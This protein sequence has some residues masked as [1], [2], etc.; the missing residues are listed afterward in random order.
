[1]HRWTSI[2][3]VLLLAAM[4]MVGCSS[5]P[6]SSNGSS[7]NYMSGE[8]AA[9]LSTAAP[10]RSAATSSSAAATSA[11]LHLWETYNN[12]QTINVFRVTSDW[13]EL[14]VTWGNFG[15]AYDP[16]V[17]G[18]FV[19]DGY[20]PHMVDVT[21]LVQG[22]TDGSVPNYGLMLDQEIYNTPRAGW[23]SREVL[24]REPYLVIT[25]D[26]GSADT[27]IASGDT[28]IREIA[29]DNNYGSSNLLY[30]GWENETDLEKQTLIRFDIT[31]PPPPPGEGCSHTIGYWK[32]HAGF[33]PQDD[34]VTPLLPIWLGAP[35]GSNSME[36][37][38]VWT[39]VNVL[40]MDVY[41]HRNNG[42]TKLM[43]QLLGTKL[44]IAD[45]ASDIDVAAAIVE[46]D[47]F[48]AEH[49]WSD[50]SSLSHSG[51]AMVMAWKDTFDAYNNGEIGPG[52]CDDGGGRECGDRGGRR[53]GHN[54]GRHG[55]DYDNG[56]GDH[57]RGRGG[58]GGGNNH[59]GGRGGRDCGNDNGHGGRGGRH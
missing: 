51:K 45:G 50:W 40:K 37:S 2:P 54:G 23:S 17:L 31:P 25:Y 24:D 46:A 32:T 9:S 6:M 20:G 18:S 43:G 53:G 29:P 22:W 57:D 27:L 28:Y 14:T 34:V 1:M 42:I 52:H 26:D 56:H 15:G 10:S 12:D 59:D 49:R 16:S 8:E 36:V 13:E 11:T 33:G 21:S 47:A 41:G 3:V 55:G 7:D 44:S 38:N 4:L 39:A 35:G 48:L 58:N 30:T 5:D 19:A